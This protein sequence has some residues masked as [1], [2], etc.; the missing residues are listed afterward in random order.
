MDDRLKRALAEAR[1]VRFLCTGNAV[2][3]AFAELYARHLGCPLPVDSAATRFQNTEL[4]A[5]TRAA[6]AARGVAREAYASFRPRHLRAL[7]PQGEGELASC[8]VFGMTADHLDAWR[9]LH[10]GHERVFLLGALLGAGDPIADPVLDGASFEDAFAT[11]E[12]CVRAL[13]DRLAGRG[14]GS[15]RATP[16]ES[17]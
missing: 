15:E 17:G 16:P 4:F 14:G 8:V 1:S 11:L 12:R 5:E 7:G 3:S 10:P 13:V 6:L 2:R 9:A